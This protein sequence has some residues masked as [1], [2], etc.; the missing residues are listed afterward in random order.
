VFA[1]TLDEH[2]RNVQQWQVEYFRQKRQQ[3]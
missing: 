3:Q 2:N 1:R